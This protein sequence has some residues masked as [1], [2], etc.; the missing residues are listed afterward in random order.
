MQKKTL[1][2][3]ADELNKYLFLKGVLTSDTSQDVPYN[4]APACYAETCT[5]SNLNNKIY[6]AEII[7]RCRISILNHSFINV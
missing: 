3:F 1:Q 4:P 6:K 5:R 2:F 7:I